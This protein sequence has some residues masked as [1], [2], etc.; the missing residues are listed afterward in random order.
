MVMLPQSRY[1]R[2]DEELRNQYPN[3]GLYRKGVPSAPLWTVEWFA[4]EVY[5]SSDGRHLIRMGP[6]PS[7]SDEL[8]VA[9]YEDGRLLC[10]YRIYQLVSDPLSLPH[11]VSHFEWKRGVSLDDAK[12]ELHVTT[13]LNEE[14]IFD[15]TTGL[16]VEGHLATA[17]EP[18]TPVERFLQRSDIAG[19]VGLGKEAYPELIETVRN[20]SGMKHDLAFFAL[21][22]NGEN[23][24]EALE[25]LGK[26]QNSTNRTMAAFGML[27][28]STPKAKAA[29]VRLLNDPVIE[30]QVSA[31]AG[32]FQIHEDGVATEAA[33]R[34]LK[35]G[36][37]KDRGN[38]LRRIRGFRPQ[39][40]VNQVSALSDQRPDLLDTISPWLQEVT[41]QYFGHLNQGKDARQKILSAWSRWWQANRDRTSDEWFVEA[42]ERD[43]TLLQDQDEWV[44]QGGFNHIQI[45]TGMDFGFSGGLFDQNGLKQWTDWWAR[46][47]HWRRGEILIESV[48]TAKT[49]SVRYSTLQ[50]L[51][52]YTDKRDVQALVDLYRSLPRGEKDYAE[53]A[54]RRL[55]NV[56][57]YG[58]TIVNGSRER[59]VI[60]NWEAFAQSEMSKVVQ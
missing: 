35:N 53:R 18:R 9:F 23:A 8:A 52:L 41:F 28:I 42:V 58:C 38:L 6:W 13:Q 55:T 25:T 17:V 46:N 59:S 4:H 5:I 50:L 32:L 40:L 22:A 30:V 21:C 45:L 49:S 10:E 54:L 20:G 36:S 24:L 39:T 15:V 26:D 16:M 12:N 29:L 60:Q 44:R 14:Y 2:K 51:Y 47:K 27:E 37:D 56:D 33:I 34:L 3:S 1:A 19:L 11:S 31:I 48:K 43:L 7:S 57:S